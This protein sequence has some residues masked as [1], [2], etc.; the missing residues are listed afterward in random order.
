MNHSH[1]DTYWKGIHVADAIDC[2]FDRMLRV[3]E[4]QCYTDT[5]SAERVEQ[6]AQIPTS[7]PMG[8][9][10]Q[11]PLEEAEVE[12]RDAHSNL[13]DILHMRAMWGHGDY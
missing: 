3:L 13:K 4:A 8:C 12:S 10:R 6:C 9:S 5:L 11:D 1:R 2:V 7:R